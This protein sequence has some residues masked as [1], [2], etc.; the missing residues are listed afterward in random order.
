[1]AKLL[2]G[3]NKWGKENG[4]NIPLTSSVKWTGNTAKLRLSKSEYDNT[5]GIVGHMHVPH[6]DHDDPGNI[7]PMV[8]AALGG[9]EC[10]LNGDENSISGAKNA[11]KQADEVGALTFDDNNNESMKKVLENYGDLAYR[12]GQAYGVPW[13]AIIVQ[14]RYEDSGS[15]GFGNMC[16]KNNFWGLACPPGTSAGGGANYTSLGEGFKGYGKFTHNG[17]YEDALKETDPYEYL[18]KLG[19]MWVQGNKNGA[20]YGSIK[21]MGK[22]IEALTKYMETDEGKE[23]IAQFGATGCD[24][25]GRCSVENGDSG[26]SS[27]GSAILEAVQKIIDLA[28][29]NGSNYVYGGGRSISNFKKVVNEGASNN[30]DCTGFASM[31]YWMVYGDEFEESDIFSSGSILAGEPSYKEVSRSEVRPGDI[32]AYQGHGGIVVEV[33]DGKVTK[34]AETG[35]KEGRSGKNQ[36]LGYSGKSDYSVRHMN[37]SAGHFY[38]WKGD[39][40]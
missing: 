22:S 38:R 11:E 5:V 27:G 4:A 14:G 25:G 37:G 7:W 24:V 40:T 16:G 19:P 21:A 8:N 18:K 34:I 20:G 32:F 23:V 35:G 6:N 2:K 12:T 3:I 26:V 29:E 28:N 39:N 15:Q 36:N 9:V 17:N 30:I 33:K 1:M 13:V 10:D 31:V